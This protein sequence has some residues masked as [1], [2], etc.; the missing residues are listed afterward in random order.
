MKHPFFLFRMVSLLIIVITLLTGCQTES[1]VK[2]PKDIW[3]MR[4]VLDYQ[5][6]MITL[7]LHQELNAAY[8]LEHGKLYKIW[9][10][11]VNYNGAA[12]NNIK[13]VQPTTWGHAYLTDSLSMS[14]WLMEQ[15]PEVVEPEFLFKGYRLKNNRLTF[16]YALVEGKD[17]VKVSESP[18]Y[19]ENERK[20]GL[21][22]TFT[23]DHTIPETRI[24]LN[25]PEGRKLIHPDVPTI[26]HHEFDRVA[27][28]PPREPAYEDD[29][30]S[31]GRYWLERS[32]CNTCHELEMMTIGPGYQQIANR[33]E[34]NEE[35]TTQLVQKVRN[36]GKG[37]WGEVPMRPHPEIDQNAL[38]QMV[39]YILSLKPKEHKPQSQTTPQS[40]VIPVAELHTPRPGFGAPL[41]DVHPAYDLISIRPESFKPRVGALAFDDEGNLLVSTWDSIGA[42]YQRMTPVRS[43]SS[44]SL[45]AWQ[46]PWGCGS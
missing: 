24:Y 33:Y 42:V 28:L 11:G 36:G 5:P 44:A 26:I 23:L 41:D 20:I 12:F 34:K 30:A 45:R 1:T 19:G 38:E 6:R 2:R 4:S 31:R 18:E 3:Y 43:G 39:S 29:L 25:T 17:T 9:K 37:N 40:E 16:H 8:D 13:T 32:G 15:G 7:F 10:G 14:V 27:K 35:N 21:V 22:R 46:N